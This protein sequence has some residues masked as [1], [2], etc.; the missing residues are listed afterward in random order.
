MDKRNRFLTLA[1]RTEKLLHSLEK[2][3]NIDKQF[4]QHFNIFRISELC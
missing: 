2:T 4:I 3:E 1:Q